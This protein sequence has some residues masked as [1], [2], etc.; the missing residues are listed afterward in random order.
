[1]LLRPL[2][3]E[4]AGG[5]SGCSAAT[6][7]GVACDAPN[8]RCKHLREFFDYL[9]DLTISQKFFPQEKFFAPPPQVKCSA[10]CGGGDGSP[11]DKPAG[12]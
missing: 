6:V 8:G 7:R 12:Y 9:I 10:T 1:R 11:A 3:A 4:L 2:S 5:Q